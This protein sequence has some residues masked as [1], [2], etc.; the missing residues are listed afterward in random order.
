MVVYFVVHDINY[1]RIK[2]NSELHFTT[3][4]ARVTSNLAI[5]EIKA[6][7]LFGYK[8]IPFFG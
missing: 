4:I 8:N 6:R 5:Y 1:F 3:S 2:Y 7:L